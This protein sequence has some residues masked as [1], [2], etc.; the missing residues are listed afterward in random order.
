M[1]HS[2]SC[3]TPSISCFTSYTLESVCLKPNVQYGFVNCSPSDD[4]DT[5]VAVG[6]RCDIQCDIGYKP[7]VTGILHCLSNG[8]W[9]RQAECSRIICPPFI[10]SSPLEN[11]DC[12]GTVF[13]SMCILSCSNGAIPSDNFLYI[14]NDSA[15]WEPVDGEINC[16]QITST[17]SSVTISTTTTTTTTTTTSATDHTFLMTTVS[18]LGSNVPTLGSKS[19]ANSGAIAG[20]VIAAILFLIVLL[21]VV[22][23]L[24]WQYRKRLVGFLNVNVPST[25]KSFYQSIPFVVVLYTV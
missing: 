20:G 14:C 8:S 19:S 12:N 18:V 24:L 17:I 5:L 4:N 7:Q 9:S 21:A 10:I 23:V 1:V 16:N 3:I 11:V 2:V 6:G 22:I 13:N 25:S 15:E